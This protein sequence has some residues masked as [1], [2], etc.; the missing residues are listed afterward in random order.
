LAIAEAVKAATRPGEHF[1][2]E[3]YGCKGCK[4]VTVEVLAVVICS[5]SSKMVGLFLFQ[6]QASHMFNLGR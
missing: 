1:D 4:T 5:T 3:K 6:M 2:F